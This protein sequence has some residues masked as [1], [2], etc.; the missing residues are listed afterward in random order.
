MIHVINWLIQVNEKG[1]YQQYWFLFNKLE[2]CTVNF[3]VN[4]EFCLVFSLSIVFFRHLSWMVFYSSSFCPGK[5]WWGYYQQR[6]FICYTF[7]RSGSNFFRSAQWNT[8][9]FCIKLTFSCLF[10]SSCFNFIN[11]KECSKRD[12]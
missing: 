4:G 11:L 6:S 2:K 9:W 8:C 3:T 7:F 12:R 1:L 5:W 10:V